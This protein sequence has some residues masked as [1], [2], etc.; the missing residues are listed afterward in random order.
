MELGL[1]FFIMAI[2]V[3]GVWVIIELKRFKHK[4]FAVFLIALILFLYVSVTH[5]I[6]Q[7]DIDFNSSSG[8]LNAGK[9]YLSWLGSLYGNMKVITG[10]AINLDWSSNETPSE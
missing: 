7:N 5:V 10:N 1:A 8:V 9:I 4:I 2:L 6:T 3:V